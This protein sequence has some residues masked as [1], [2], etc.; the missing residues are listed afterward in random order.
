VKLS[1]LVIFGAGYVL[2]SRAGR[3]RYEQ[4]RALASRAADNYMQPTTRDRI[5]AYSQRLETF[6]SGATVDVNGTKP[7]RV[8]SP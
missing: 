6:A 2:G 5:S 8:K 1:S 3:E 4:L 7:L